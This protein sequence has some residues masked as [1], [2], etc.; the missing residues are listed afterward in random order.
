MELRA[1]NRGYN[2]SNEIVDAV[3]L[4]LDRDLDCGKYVKK[5][6][7][8]KFVMLGSSDVGKTSIANKYTANTFNVMTG[9]TIGSAFYTN[10]LKTKCGVMTLNIWDTAGQE[11]YNSIVPMYFRNV[12]VAIIVFDLTNFNSLDQAKKWYDKINDKTNI[13]YNDNSSMITI[14]VG[15]KCDK[16][17][18]IISV[19]E[20]EAE[21][22]CD[23]KQNLHF[24]K[25]S[26]KTGYGVANIFCHAIIKKIEQEKDNIKDETNMIVKKD[27]FDVYPQQ[28]QNTK[29]NIE[30]TCKCFM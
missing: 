4:K 11:R 16:T 2:R 22:Y 5:N 27:E 8:Y 30:K 7:S 24:I 29:G 13:G 25:T 21:K 17:D 26:A 14:L 6:R 10:D 28:N 15:N 20:E 18:F 1:D 9:T 12:D 23:L 3:L 19:I